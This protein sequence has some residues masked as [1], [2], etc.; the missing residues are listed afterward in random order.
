MPLITNAF[1]CA[2]NEVAFLSW[3]VAGMIAGCLG[4][5]IQRIHMDGAEPP[6]SLAAFVPFPGQTNTDWTPRDTA[7]WPVRN[8]PGGI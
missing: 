5:D 2:N 6:K 8:C 4:F 3:E 7:I 1:A